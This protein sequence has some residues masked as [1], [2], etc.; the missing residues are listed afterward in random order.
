MSANFVLFDIPLKPRV[1]GTE[2]LYFRK[3]KN[4]V[5]FNTFFGAVP[6]SK[7]KK[8][9]DI[10]ALEFDFNAKA[11]FDVQIRTEEK[12]IASGSFYEHGKISVKLSDIP[13]T[14]KLL[15][16]VIGTE[17][18]EK[19]SVLA[20][21]ENVRKILP[22]IVICTYHREQFAKKNASLLAEYLRKSGT[23]GQ[24]IVVDNGRTLTDF[25]DERI[26][27]IPNANTGGS[28]GYKKGM[29][30]ACQRG[31][32]HFLLMDDDVEIDHTAVQRAIGFLKCLKPEYKDIS[33]S[34]SMLYLDKPTRQFEAGGHFYEDGTQRGFG[35][36]L[37]LSQEKALLLNEREND[38]NY[39]GWWYMLMPSKYAEQGNF[40]LP[41]FMK[42]DDVEYALRCKQKII[43]LNGVG[44]WHEKFESK[45][46]SS[47]EYYNTRNYLFLCSLHCKDFNEQKAKN[48]AKKQMKAKRKRQQYKMAQAV[49]RG[50]EDYLKG[51][52]YLQSLDAE[53]NHREI[54]KLNYEYIS[55][56]EIEKR[57]GVRPA[58]NRFY[59]PPDVRP[60]IRLL[61]PKKYI[62]TDKFFDRP[63]QYLTAKYAVHCDPDRNCGYVTGRK[64]K[65]IYME[66]L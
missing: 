25:S 13:D 52:E 48:F 34:G 30:E 49:K 45:Y 2:K 17:K 51:L 41:F 65:N 8:Y 64:N 56:D 62:F 27:L 53:A 24:V 29:E 55:Y 1:E 19:I 11:N 6:I 5:S 59:P 31:F 63:V 32:T 10:T 61:F 50:Y 54:C 37:D 26:T 39:G 12:Q 60:D 22:A 42:Y 4:C 7:I 18:I 23:S 57:Y 36:Y 46:N 28:G 38:I 40:P 47:S 3:E 14:S 21:C 33:I 15:Y 58:D 20:E 35:H 16:P 44:I 66:E 9:T 43:T